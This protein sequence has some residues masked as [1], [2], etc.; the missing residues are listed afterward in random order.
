MILVLLLAWFL[1]SVGIFLC[2]IAAAYYAYVR[3][4]PQT[5]LVAKLIGAIAA[6]VAI[7]IPTGFVV[8]LYLFAQAHSEGESTLDAKGLV[9]SFLCL[10][11]EALV[12]W[13]LCSAIVGRLVGTRT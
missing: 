13:L 8:G 4:A 9:V 12:G 3:D 1:L 5:E 7:V 2:I 11:F 6:H 10:G